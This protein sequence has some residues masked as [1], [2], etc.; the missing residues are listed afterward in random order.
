MSESRRDFR[1]VWLS[2]ASVRR[3]PTE[4]T[5][6]TIPVYVEPGGTRLGVVVSSR[7]ASL[8]V[9]VPVSEIVDLSL[10]QGAVLVEYL[11]THEVTEFN[12]TRWHRYLAKDPC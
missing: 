1:S 6:G 12:G 7:P 10:R 2:D 11:P 9:V 8:E 4:A 3:L 5:S